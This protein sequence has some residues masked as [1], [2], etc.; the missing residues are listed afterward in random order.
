MQNWMWYALIGAAAYYAMTQMQQP[1]PPA[2]IPADQMRE[3]QLE[4]WP[5]TSNV[6][7][8]TPV[9]PSVSAAASTA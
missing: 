8:N 3:A 5:P 7:P 1:A 2:D 6:I 9:G 4:V